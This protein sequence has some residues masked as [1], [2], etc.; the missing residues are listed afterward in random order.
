MVCINI[1]LCFMI[2]RVNKLILL[3]LLLVLLP[4]FALS[5]ESSTLV[6]GYIYKADSC[7]NVDERLNYY[8]KAENQI[9]D[10]TDDSL[11]LVVN[12]RLG[13]LL[14]DR[15]D[16]SKA[17]NYLLKAISCSEK[18]NTEWSQC[19]KSVCLYVMATAYLNQSDTVGMKTILQ[20]MRVL[21]KDNK[22]LPSIQYD[23]YSVM[24][25]YY[26]LLYQYSEERADIE[27]SMDYGKRSIGYQMQM[28]REEW[29]ENN[30][31]PVW[32]YYNV[33]V[34]YDMYYSPMPVDSIEKYLD[35]A[36]EVIDIWEPS[37][38]DSLEVMISLEDERAWLY[39]YR[40]NYEG[41]VQTMLH[42][43]DMIEVVEQVSPNTVIT[44]R[45]EAYSFFVELYSAT[46]N[47]QK[48]LE[49]EQLLE[50]N[51]RVRYDIERSR[52]IHEVVTRYEVERH[53]QELVNLTAKN[54][55]MH[56]ALVWTLVSLVLL[57][58]VLLL[59]VILRRQRKL[60]VE[61]RLYEKALEA[62]S[63]T[64]NVNIDI[65]QYLNR[66]KMNYPAHSELF[67]HVDIKHIHS[68]VNKSI[69]P[70]T[71]MDIRYII[72]FT[73]GLKP[74]QIAQMMNVEPGSV[75]TVRYRL[76]K[77]LGADVLM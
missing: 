66:L 8:S 56:R 28:T 36:Y 43:L 39:Y 45:G 60:V 41:A 69:S 35:M 65:A 10:D 23:Y 24:Q 62:D 25:A 13:R 22:T 71:A 11:S 50:E 70:L 63:I 47:W 31:N 1:V 74:A 58:L 54:K 7:T 61:Q 57:L 18:I 30:V 64:H 9:T 21:A 72:C 26:S 77:K 52:A 6:M 4:T 51:N 27:L 38:R 55:I 73:S 46:G 59:I 20:K 17:H 33:A 16:V 29:L 15:G 76:K 49:Y 67:D 42:V 2:L 19:R 48:A 3:C 12:Y 68:I 44:E 37:H 34:C 32:T 75:Y 5:N 53:E 14:S 40:N